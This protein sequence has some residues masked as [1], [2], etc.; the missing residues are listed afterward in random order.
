MKNKE[1][2]QLLKKNKLKS[3]SGFT[4]IE[5]L[6]GL[7]MS[8]F[9]IG[10]LGF[11]LMQVLSTTR[12]QTSQVDIRNETSRALDFISDEVR[13][14]RVIETNLVNANISRATGAFDIANTNVEADGTFNTD[15]DTVKKIVF[16][17]DIPEVSNSNRLDTDADAGTPERIIYYL[18][19]ASGTNWEGPSVL[20][21]WGPPFDANGDYTDTAWQEEALI[22]GIDNTHIDEDNSQCAAG[23]V[24]TPPLLTGTAPTLS[25][26]NL[27]TAATGFY[28]CING[29]NT[30][31]L[32]LTGQTD[33]ANG[34]VDTYTAD[35]RVVARARDA[36]PNRVNNFTSITWNF[37]D[38]GGSYHGGVCNPGWQMRTDF[39]SDPDDPDN[40]ISW[41][42]DPNRQPQPIE[43]DPSKP[44]T[45]TSSPVGATGC[46]SRGNDGTVG[47]EDLSS[48]TVTVSHTIDFGDP[49]T[50]NGDGEEGSAQENYDVTQ[51]DSTKP[52]VQF[53]KRGSE[54][55]IY[56]GFDENDDGDL[57]DPNDQP[58]LGKFL[59]NK[60]MAVLKNPGD[61]PN[62]PNTEFILPETSSDPTI[63]I[64]GEDQRI[65]A[66]E[67][68]Q[69][70][71]TI[72]GNP[73]PGFDLQDN[74]FVVTS[75]I[76]KKKF[77]PGCFS[78][79]CPAPDS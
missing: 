50:F 25:G 69:T 53:L 44:L 68:G 1:F 79:N 37:Q 41:I 26:A 10:A 38:I 5:L 28:A 59:Y 54:I 24:P 31:Q 3:N 43:V 78:G 60:K 70:Q 76:F 75:D 47:N 36:L 7:F 6:I 57:D 39:G 58:S 27:S 11:G 13:R 52:G 65:I 32:F 35:T 74:I 62:D 49:I 8:T 42:R 66:F 20:Y 64:L 34:G 29:T 33:T 15:P 72:V 56:G 2:H 77:P 61:D 18:R 23:E 46:L 4:L 45:I 67:V 9:V 16:A 21:R 17:L 55:P 14:A 63:K 40:T 48:Y 19:S 12:T 22:D 51:V 71:T 73:N 30:A